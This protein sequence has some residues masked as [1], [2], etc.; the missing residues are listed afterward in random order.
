MSRRVHCARPA[1]V[2]DRGGWLD[3]WWQRERLALARRL[4][5][6]LVD[7]GRPLAIR[8]AIRR[9]ASC[10]WRKCDSELGQQLGRAYRQRIDW[11]QRSILFGDLTGK[12]FP[13]VSATVQPEWTHEHGSFTVGGNHVENDTRLTELLME[14]SVGI[15]HIITSNVGVTGEAYWSEN[16]TGGGGSIPDRTTSNYGLRFGFTI[17]AR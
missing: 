1:N 12:T 7:I 5:R 3:S 4:E 16:K 13:F 9:A 11:T 15:T 14:G 17:F 10:R 8:V 2:A 6:S